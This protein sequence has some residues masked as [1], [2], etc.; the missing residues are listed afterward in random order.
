[1]NLVESSALFSDKAEKYALQ[2]DW[3]RLCGEWKRVTWPSQKL[4]KYGQLESSQ[5]ADLMKRCLLE[6]AK[7]QNAVFARVFDQFDVPQQIP[8]DTDTPEK[9]L[10]FPSVVSQ[11]VVVEW[12]KVLKPLVVENLVF[13]GMHMSLA[14]LSNLAIVD[15]LNGQFDLLMDCK[16]VYETYTPALVSNWHFAYDRVA[17]MQIWLLRGY[18]CEI[19]GELVDAQNYYS[20]IEQVQPS[21]PPNSA[22]VDGDKKKFHSKD[23]WTI[24]AEMGLYRL[25]FTLLKLGHIERALKV[26]RKYLDYFSYTTDQIAENPYPSSVTNP[27]LLSAQQGT[28]NANAPENDKHPLTFFQLRKIAVLKYYLH[29]CLQALP[30]VFS[31]VFVVERS[32]KPISLVSQPPKAKRPT[33]T[34]QAIRA[35]LISPRSKNTLAGPLSVESVA[36]SPTT[37]AG[38]TVASSKLATYS[39]HCDAARF[40]PLYTTLITTVFPFPSGSDLSPIHV[41][42]FRTTEDCAD[43]WIKSLF[44][45]LDHEAPLSYW[46]HPQ[47]LAALFNL[48]HVL[49]KLSLHSFQQLRLFRYLSHA[50]CLLVVAYGSFQHSCEKVEALLAVEAYINLYK[51]R[52]DREVSRELKRR[53]DFQER[54]NSSDTGSIGVAPTA[55][56]HIGRTFGR[57]KSATESPSVEIF[58]VEGETVLDCIGV[59]IAGMSLCHLV[60][61][62]K[63]ALIKKGI[64]LGLFAS[65]LLEKHGSNLTDNER[66]VALEQVYQNLAILHLD[67]AN[68]VPSLEQRGSSLAVSLNYAQSSV[69]AVQSFTTSNCGILYTLA[70]GHG[71]SGHRDAAVHCNTQYLSYRPHD[72]EAVH[73]QALLESAQGDVDLA[74]EAIDAGLLA[75]IKQ[76]PQISNPV[77]L[78]SLETMHGTLFPASLYNV[79]FSKVPVL[80]CHSLF[81]LILTEAF[82]VN[83]KLGAKEALDRC[84]SLLALWRLVFKESEDRRSEGKEI[85][86]VENSPLL[87]LEADPVNPTWTEPH[88]K[89][90]E[91]FPNLSLPTAE[92]RALLVSSW[93][94]ISAL[95]RTQ[96]CF[97]DAKES[98]EEA[99]S[100]LDKLGQCE[101]ARQKVLFNPKVS[102]AKINNTGSTQEGKFSRLSARSSGSQ[103]VSSSWK[104]FLPFLTSNA[105]QK[106]GGS[107]SESAKNMPGPVQRKCIADV[108]LE[109]LLIQY[110]EN[111]RIWELNFASLSQNNSWQPGIKYQTPTALA[112]LGL[113]QK[114]SLLETLPLSA[115][116]ASPTSASHGMGASAMLWA[117]I[118]KPSHVSHLGGA[119]LSVAQDGHPND[120]PNSNNFGRS[121]LTSMS[122]LSSIGSRRSLKLKNRFA[123]QLKDSIIHL[124]HGVVGDGPKREPFKLSKLRR[125]RHKAKGT[126]QVNGASTE[127]PTSNGSPLGLS[128]SAAPTP[129]AQLQGADPA[130][131]AS[132]NSHAISEV[133]LGPSS[134]FDINQFVPNAIDDELDLEKLRKENLETLLDV[135]HFL[136][137]IDSTHLATFVFL[138]SLYKELDEPSVATSVLE[139]V[140]NHSKARGGVGGGGAASLWLGGLTG[141]W[142]VLGLSIW[143]D[144]FSKIDMLIPSLSDVDLNDSLNEADGDS[145][146]SKLSADSLL[147]ED[148]YSP[149]KVHLTNDFLINPKPLFT[150]PAS[151]DINNPNNCIKAPTPPVLEQEKVKLSPSH[152][153]QC[154]LERQT[155]LQYL[156]DNAV[157]WQLCCPIRGYE[158]LSTST[159]V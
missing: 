65:S 118:E 18:Y 47:R 131:A 89:P 154:A 133:P 132:L 92:S 3:E 120:S 30:V 137:T 64:N 39:E 119:S 44:A 80:D 17:M 56:A 86:A 28:V 66:A 33:A 121:K 141:R 59:C 10:W 107:I 99:L 46:Q 146:S 25:F 111:S 104:R 125:P 12:I 128:G 143:S 61:E 158:V 53:Q 76:A 81:N 151:F 85:F 77:S 35:S 32:G 19:R 110:E 43:W 147:S 82:L 90:V 27:Y 13:G 113:S 16:G 75:F 5:K 109:A 36:P 21:E 15:V 101:E 57:Q 138:A 45:K 60:H 142:G 54:R 26:G 73:L 31:G 24:W 126:P 58:V 124:A 105:D 11:D 62:G 102:Y 115:S 6:T 150:F 72:L 135:A 22:F 23:Q 159:K 50:F 34:A 139:R 20:F 152:A 114:Y 91:F 2:L 94:F 84:T 96:S 112:R 140:L 127:V 145:L 49:Y 29:H 130:I 144:A 88:V 153:M 106:R 78:E 155:K 123:D 55:N 157:R 79:D 7:F 63:H 38:I 71:L 9:P 95:L 40:L 41:Q 148:I 52:L 69:S 136:L 83:Q 98:I 117:S 87:C 97:D 108:G 100:V 14:A 67:F 129:A 93:L 156:L 149:I 103:E 37:A 70:L 8:W 42:R 51:T 4:I 1:M 134:D 74:L 68:E 122:S 48:I 116:A